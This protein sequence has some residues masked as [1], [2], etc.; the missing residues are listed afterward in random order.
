MD[1][2]RLILF[3]VFSFSLLLLWDSW[4]R[5][6]IS[7]PNNK[8]DITQ[9]GIPS[10][11]TELTKQADLPDI[12]SGYQLL[13]GK[14]IQVKTD[15]YD[16]IIS[17]I[18]GDIR[19]LTLSDHLAD[20]YVDN[21]VL[22]S[23]SSDPLLYVAQSGLL[24]KN[25]PSHKSKFIFEQDSYTLN[26]DILN[27]PMTYNSSEV[28]VKKT[29]RFS[30]NSY[31]I[32]VRYDIQNKTQSTITP[33]AYFQLI[34]DGDSNQGAKLTPSFTGPAYYTNEE[35]FNKFA[36]SKADKNAF[37]LISKD[38]W[39]GIIQRYFASAWILAEPVSR[40]LYSKKIADNIYAAGMVTKLPNIESNKNV[41]FAVELY[42]GPQSKDDLVL[43]AKGM[44]YTVDY[45]WLTIIASPLFSVLSGIYKMVGNWGIAII[46]LTVLIKLLFY[47]LSAASYRSMAQMRE[48]APRLAS[49]K[50][51]FGDD[52]QKMQQAMMELYKTEKINPLGGCLPILIQIPVFIALYWVLLG[53]VELRHAPF[54][55]WI[56]DLS[57][58]D[59]YYILPILM[60]ASMF[61]QT[62]LN[63]KPTDPM[64]AKLMMW[65]PI[66]F[67]IFF[68]FFPAGLVLYWLVNNILSIAQQ[69]YVN[70]K[71]H[72]ETLKKKGNA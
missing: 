39:M 6:N 31:L 69:A 42:A 5:Q 46:L 48:L 34:H 45:G 68:F 47:P 40:E 55:G 17:E 33:S 41:S 18:G 1:T 54:F 27:V 38:G 36:F 14:N 61:L 23:D 53:S 66:V 63:P 58:S 43:A 13:N 71:I 20:N 21:Y 15:K 52:K 7:P 65:M 25:L 57:V 49:M 3:V 67:S 44:K 11:S 59:P 51:R 2:K 29:Y 28:S 72:A 26:G 35:N 16:L 56:S 60:A 70:K 22:Y 8:V 19:K 32:N 10:P 4:Q 50:E 37:S 12:S 64:Q 24:G 30:K 62:K 9:D